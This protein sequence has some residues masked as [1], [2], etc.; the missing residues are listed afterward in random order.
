MNDLNEL[1]NELVELVDK[2]YDKLKDSRMSNYTYYNKNS[3]NV[4]TMVPLEISLT[5]CL[6]QPLDEKDEMLLRV[7]QLGKAVGIS[8]FFKNE[9]I[10]TE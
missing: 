1:V 3:K 8:I 7:Q 2:R 6:I 10:A 4:N 9:Q 5:Y